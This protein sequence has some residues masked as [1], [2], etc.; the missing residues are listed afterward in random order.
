VL[1]DRGEQGDA[2]DDA[3]DPATVVDDD[4][5]GGVLHRVVEQLVDRSVLPH[6]GHL[7]DGG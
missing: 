3:G 4:D 6:D 5:G 2:R 7:V 1:T